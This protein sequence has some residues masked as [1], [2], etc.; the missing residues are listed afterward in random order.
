[1]R[2]DEFIADILGAESVLTPSEIYAKRFAKK[3]L[4]GYDS[5]E[6]DDFL[7]RV[8]D[9][10]ELL[11]ERIYELK[12]KVEEQSKLIDHYR[13]EESIL[14]S[15]L[16][17]AQRLNEEIIETAQRQAQ[18]IVAEAQA[19]AQQIPLRLEQEIQHL[20]HMRDR[21]HQEVKTLLISFQSLLSEYESTRLKSMYFEDR[22]VVPEQMKKDF[23]RIFSG[24]QEIEHFDKLEPKLDENQ[25]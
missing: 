22:D 12:A 15:A 23:D 7:R 18:S 20:V 25:R 5:K 10:I 11:T 19:R 13:E 2:R 17:S 21:F 3:T 8:A 16:N 24:D 9:T 14:R 6:V 4:G 1:M